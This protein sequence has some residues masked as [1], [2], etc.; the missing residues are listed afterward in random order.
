MSDEIKVIKLE[1][2]SELGIS[3]ED[4]KEYQEEWES[5]EKQEFI[6]IIRINAKTTNA[7]GETETNR[8]FLSSIKR[9]DGKNY[10]IPDGMVAVVL[11]SRTIRTMMPEYKPG[12]SGSGPLCHSEDMLTGVGK[13][14]GECVS[15]RYKDMKNE[16]NKKLCGSQKKIL[17]VPLTDGNG[18]TL[19]EELSVPHVL[20]AKG[21]SFIPMNNLMA[22]LADDMRNNK[23]PPFSRCALISLRKT[24]TGNAYWMCPITKPASGKSIDPNSK[25]F[26]IKNLSS[27]TVKKMFG[28]YKDHGKIFKGQV[29]RHKVAYSNSRSVVSS[30]E[31]FGFEEV[32]E[33]PID[34]SEA[35][36]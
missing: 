21:T 19:P 2:L 15:C 31:E 29:A 10:T 13:P 5:E 32:P 34:A 25:D 4:S 26:T 9:A 6:P 33:E 24:D 11:S 36:F 30:P 14:G 23:I 8:E 35:D 27:D 17:L 7:D 20:Y 22:K 12:V 3:T 28:L 18:K 16:K 1:D